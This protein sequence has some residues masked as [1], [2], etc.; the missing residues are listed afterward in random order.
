MNPPQSSRKLLG[1]EPLKRVVRRKEPQRVDPVD[2]PI[3]RAARV[4]V[5]PIH[6]SSS[7]RRSRFCHHCFPTVLRLLCSRARAPIQ[8]PVP[9]G[10][11]LAPLLRATLHRACA[12]RPCAALDPVQTLAAIWQQRRLPS[13]TRRRRGFG[14]R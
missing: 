10:H 1:I 7:S 5:D 14:R 13:R 6:L 2:P 11:T 9:T 4:G 8:P 3:N 12:S